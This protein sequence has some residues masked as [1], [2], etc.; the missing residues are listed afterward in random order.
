MTSISNFWPPVTSEFWPLV[1]SL[2][3]RGQIQITYFIAGVHMSMHAKNCISGNCFK[4]LTSMTSIYSFWPLVTF[5]D[6]GGQNYIAYYT[7]WTLLFPISLR[8][9]LYHYRKLRFGSFKKVV[10]YIYMC[11]YI[12]GPLFTIQ[13]LISR[14]PL[15]QMAPYLASS[16]RIRILQYDKVW[17]QLDH[18]NL[19]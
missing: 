13:K 6:L 2:D 5:N 19:F 12:Y 16:S 3:L 1:T 18:G 7:S 8:S 9:S 15:G 10:T 11:I 14:D 4:L 17:Y